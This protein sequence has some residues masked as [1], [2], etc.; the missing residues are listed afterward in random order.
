MSAAS[1]EN[2]PDLIHLVIGGAGFIGSALSKRLLEDHEHVIVV[3]NNL[4]GRVEIERN[5]HP[6][7]TYVILESEVQRSDLPSILRS[8]ISEMKVVIWHLAANSDI[9]AGA[10]SPLLDLQNT[11]GSTLGVLNLMSQLNVISVYFASTSAVYGNLVESNFSK[12]SDVCNPI[13][14]Y[15]AMKLASE[16]LLN[17]S[18]ERASVPLTIF[19]FANIVGTPSTHGVIHDFIEKLSC[20]AEKLDVLGDGSQSK[21]Y[22]HVQQLV[23]MMLCAHKQGLQGVYNLGP[24]DNGIEVRR[25]VEIL[26]EH[27]NHKFSTSYQSSAQGWPGDVVR[28]RMEISK[29]KRD[30][31]VMAVS[32]L[33]SVHMALHDILAAKSIAHNCAENFELKS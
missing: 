29:A 28:S 19:R 27:Y 30:I 12:E 23:D 4:S 32:S 5:T 25:I 7:S 24:G 21:T 8:H 20:N 10:T 17:I 6:A 15:G 14:Y 3:D 16:H 13:S 2:I 18:A 26:S 11:L 31:P 1:K 22:L 33:Q 9:Q